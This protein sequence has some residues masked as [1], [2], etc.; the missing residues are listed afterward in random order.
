MVLLVD[1]GANKLLTVLLAFSFDQRL[2]YIV[3]LRAV[4]DNGTTRSSLELDTFISRFTFILTQHILFSL[5]CCWQLRKIVDDAGIVYLGCAALGIECVCFSNAFRPERILSHYPGDST[6]FHTAI[7][8][9]ITIMDPVS[10][11][12]KRRPQ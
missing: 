7:E 6:S 5:T 3:Q 10:R 8:E 2:V 12:Y 11:D 1:K 4:V 9:L